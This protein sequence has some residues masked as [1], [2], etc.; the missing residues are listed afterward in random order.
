[1]PINERRRPGDPTREI[2]LTGHYVLPGVVDVH[3]HTRI[4]SD[5]L[6]DRFFD[7]RQRVFRSVVGR[8]SMSD[9]QLS[10]KF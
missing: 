3:T 7:G 8:P 5:A 4:P 2:D 1:M 6:P 10:L 9:D